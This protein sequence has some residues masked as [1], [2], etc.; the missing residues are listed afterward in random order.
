LQLRIYHP[1]GAGPFP[2]V[3]FSHGAGG[4]KDGYEYFGEFMA[5]H[6]FVS[7]QPSHSGTGTALLYSGSGKPSETLETIRKAVDDPVQWEERVK[8]VRLVLDS[9]ATIAPEAD[10]TRI[11][12]AG[13]SYG[14]MTTMM[15]EGALVNMPGR[16]TRFK[17]PRFRA[18]I[19]LS[20]QGVGPA[21]GPRAWDGLRSPTLLFTGSRDEGIRGQPVSWR[22]AVYRALPAG[23][24]YLV[25]IAGATHLSFVDHELPGLQM[26][27][28]KIWIAHEAVTKASL[29]FLRAY[30]LK[31]V[32][33]KKALTSGLLERQLGVAVR[34]EHK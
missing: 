22:L 25:N 19:A 24:K 6:G 26:D 13:H 28:G 14:A 23:D 30:L 2:V 15:L 4:S 3:I 32:S 12:M 5:A 9:L 16:P 11:A 18:F 33:A 29:A 21:F 8:D 31:D 20:P 27:M 7:I 17:E 34:L 10:P 1:E